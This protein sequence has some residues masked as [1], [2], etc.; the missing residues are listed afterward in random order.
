MELMYVEL[1]LDFSHTGPAWIGH[2]EINR[3]RKTIYFNGKVF[4]KGRGRI[5]NYVDIDDRNEYWISGIKKNGEDRHWAGHGKIQIDKS[6]IEAYLNI[7][8]QSK[9]AAN[10]YNVVELINV[11]NKELANHI[12]NFKK[13]TN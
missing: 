2:G 7:T 8:Q 9:L 1:I 3:S 10:K 4:G 6:S 5:G 13:G 12:E 11:P